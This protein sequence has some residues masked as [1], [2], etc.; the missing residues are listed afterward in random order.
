MVELFEAEE[1]YIQHLDAHSIA[2]LFR[3]LWVYREPRGISDCQH[4][5]TATGIDLQRQPFQWFSALNIEIRLST[6][7]SFNKGRIIVR[8][9]PDHYASS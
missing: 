5:G 9:A 2:L 6:L 3:S 8:A 4:P 1:E 7:S